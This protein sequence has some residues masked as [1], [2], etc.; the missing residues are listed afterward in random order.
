MSYGQHR[1]SITTPILSVTRSG[2]SLLVFLHVLAMY[3][4]LDWHEVL[5]NPPVADTDYATHWAEVW[6][7][8]HFLE[9]GRLWGYDPFFMAGHPE[10]TLFD[11]D[12]K[13]IEV[14][15]FSLSRAGL[16]LPLSYNLV[17]VSLMA[18]APL[19]V[20]PAGHWLGLGRGQA[21]LAQLA[22]LGL[23]YLDPALRWSWQ[24]STLA[25]AS[26]VCL[27]LLVLAAA[28]HLSRPESS[29][30]PAAWLLWFVL[31]P[32]LFWLHAMTF[33]ILLLPLTLWTL[34]SWRKL[35]GTQRATLLLWPAL[36][37]LANAPWLLGAL[38]FHWAR[39]ASNQYL[40]G[41]LP[42]LAADLVGLG[43]VDGAST[44]SLIGLRWLVMLLGGLGLWQ[45][46]RRGTV[47]QALASGAWGGL[48]V[49]YGAVYLPGGGNLQPYRYIEQAAIWST[50]GIGPGLRVL[51]NTYATRFPQRIW[52]GI[53]AIITL[54]ATLWVG[55]AAWRFRP[56]PLGGPAHHR[57]QGPSPAA[58]E[59]CRHLKELP[60]ENGRLLTDDSRLGALL[61]WCSG[62]QVIGGH[63]F[64]IWTQYGYTNATIRD[65][66]DVP[67][68]NYTVATWRDALKRYNVRWIIAHEEWNIPG[69]YTLS[70]WL[71]N[72]PRQ[73][74]A[75]PRFGPYRFY[76]PRDAVGELP[77]TILAEHGRLLITDAPDQSFT[78]PFHWISYLRAAPPSVRLSPETVGDDP[79]PFIRVE[80][81]GNATIEICTAYPWPSPISISQSAC[82]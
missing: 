42:A 13:L 62:A 71:A 5:S 52:V 19:A 79:I 4:F 49:A 36:V 17:L 11:L 35:S 56:P 55:N 2:F 1:K 15:A 58:K 59:V 75:G 66:L 48:L 33:L 23:W 26:T 14:A 21:L 60:L 80:P 6:S 43:R 69:W 73:V 28:V 44:V 70:D 34:R 27:S 63:F 41:G 77:F 3:L 50:L 53:V 76:Q 8:S 45:M 78:L 7:V 81:A 24:G 31:G 57:W 30:S 72:H 22:A 39:M 29:P 38:R 54:F 9:N 46:A 64:E 37:L 67:Y 47:G 61:P 18:L 12:N 40:Q 74:I 82:R 10:G 16:P 20:Y 51:A 65:F 68:E 25:F 32:L